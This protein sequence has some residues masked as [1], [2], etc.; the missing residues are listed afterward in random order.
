M[1]FEY[2]RQIAAYELLK[3]P[4]YKKNEIQTEKSIQSKVKSSKIYG[5]L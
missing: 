5:K 1:N 4:N 3:R 2:C